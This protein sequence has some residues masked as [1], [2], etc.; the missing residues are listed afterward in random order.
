[1]LSF[2][3]VV[4]VFVICLT[5]IQSLNSKAILTLKQRKYW[6]S[7]NSDFNSN[8]FNQPNVLQNMDGI[9]KREMLEPT[10]DDMKT[11]TLILANI[12]EFIDFKPE[13][14]MSIVTKNMGWMYQRNI[15]K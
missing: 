5:G 6:L 3:A 13:V 9:T 8:Q 14:A 7:P 10:V 11:F 15:P 12:T 1:M 2:V 4:S